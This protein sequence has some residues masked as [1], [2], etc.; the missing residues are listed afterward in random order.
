MN[1]LCGLIYWHIDDNYAHMLLLSNLGV[2]EL[3][4][5]LD[6]INKY[7]NACGVMNTIIY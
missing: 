5:A 4:N 1:F 3:F 6:G 2:V 7:A